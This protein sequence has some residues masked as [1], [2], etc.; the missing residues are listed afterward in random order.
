MTSSRILL[1]TAA[2]A[3]STVLVLS[4]CGGQ[5]SDADTGALRVVTSTNVYSDIVSQVA[6]DFAEVDPIIDDPNRSEE[7]RVAKECRS[8]WSPYH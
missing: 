2:I 1:T 5:A 8:R 3:S 4:G 6:G 7:R